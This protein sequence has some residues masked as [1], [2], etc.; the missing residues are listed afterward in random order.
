MRRAILFSLCLAGCRSTDRID[1]L[2]AQL[3]A[4]DIEER[5]AVCAELRACGL[6]ALTRL[7]ETRL[8][9][10]E[11]EARRDE[12]VRRIERDEKLRALC[13]E[14]VRARVNYR[15]TL[16][17]AAATVA[18]RFGVTITV[19]EGAEHSP[20][21][22]SLDHASLVEAL[23]ALGDWHPAGPRRYHLSGRT[24]PPSFAS[25]RFCVRARV[26]DGTLTLVP[27]HDGE[28]RALPLVRIEIARALDASGR[29]LELPPMPAGYCVEAAG[30]APVRAERPATYR[31]PLGTARIAVLEGALTFRFATTSASVLLHT[32][33]R[34]LWTV[35]GLA[36]RAEDAGTRLG[37]DLAVD[38][39]EPHLHGDVLAELLQERTVATLRDGT[40]RACDADL[41]S[42]RSSCLYQTGT[43]L[44]LHAQTQRYVAGDWQSIELVLV[45]GVIEKRIPFVIRDIRGR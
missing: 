2:I 4:D 22:L 9:T 12:I 28:V 19:V 31:W 24:A 35:G 20:A 15:G 43:L 8:M 18:S 27:Q 37:C 38:V 16:A 3:D 21:S 23:C 29:P 14:P 45:D 34:G 26:R 11:A 1:A 5:D 30:G 40:G 25:G 44:A 42:R 17:G 7:R 33:A 6:T 39:A 41:P 36:L 32:E 13:P 10:A